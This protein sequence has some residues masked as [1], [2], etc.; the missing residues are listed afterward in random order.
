M[1]RRLL[2]SACLLLGMMVSAL[3]AFAVQP[4]EVL[5]DP[6]LE[7]RAR[8]L[9]AGLRCLVCQN[10]SI[11]DSDAPLAQDLRR[12]VR[13]RLVS[14]DSD[15][16]VKDFVVARY[17]EFVLLKPPFN[18]GTL[19]LWLSPALVFLLGGFALWRMLRRRPLP[20]VETPVQLSAAEQAELD[21][22]TRGDL[23]R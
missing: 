2:V 6:A 1:P 13:E 16:Q 4:H 21:R 9:S 8:A 18:T 17:G 14:G 20:A 19:L 11:D 10:Q 15:R 5:K 7:S 23:R 12:L 3:P 22:L